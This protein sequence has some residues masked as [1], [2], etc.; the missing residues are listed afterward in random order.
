MDYKLTEVKEQAS[1]F[2]INKK[3]RNETTFLNYRT[4]INYFIYYIENIAEAEAI[5]EDNIEGLLD[6]FQNALLNGFLY[7]VE[8]KKR[9]VKVKP[10]GINTHIRRT[11]SFLN[12]CFKLKP[13]ITKLDVDKPKYKSLPKSH[14]ELLANECSNYF[15][16]NEIAVR[17]E[18]LIRFLFNSAFRIEEALGIKTSNVY[19]ENNNYYVKIHEKG[20][21]KGV[22]TEITISEKSYKMLMD[23]INI[24]KVPSDFLF[25]STGKETK[26]SRRQF[27]NN[28]KDL[29]SYVDIKYKGYKIEDKEVNISKTVENNSSHFLRH[30][31]AVYLLNK[32]KEDVVT[33]QKVLRHKSIN[34]T[35]IYLNPEEE[36]INLVRINNDI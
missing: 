14:I 25:S 2:L 18:T 13:E 15:S 36:A 21:A 1:K 26:F 6:S 35:L 32:E 16:N 11:K 29:A 9:T 12:K 7:V 33:V 17:T 31:K 30:S 10:S 28:I 20:K 27:N 5:N 19:S 22:L 4:S 3:D 24:K 23:Y 34:S 8:D